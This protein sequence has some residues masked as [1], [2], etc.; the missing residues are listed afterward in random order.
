[1]KQADP[2]TATAR[3]QALRSDRVATGSAVL[4]MTYE[5]GARRRERRIVGRTER[6]LMIAAVLAC[7]AAAIAII[8]V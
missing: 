7:N 3:L 2:R 4:E 5:C 1:M 6:L 8:L